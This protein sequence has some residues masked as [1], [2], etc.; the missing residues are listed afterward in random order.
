MARTQESIYNSSVAAYV[1]SA[2]AAGIITIVPSAWSMYNTQ[3]LL[4]WT[5]A[6]LISQFEQLF[7]DYVATTEAIV[8]VA[9]PQTPKWFKHQMFLFQFDATTPQVIQLDDVNGTFSPF[10][11]TTDAT[12]RIVTSCSVVPGSRGSTLIKL[13]KG[14]TTP[15]PLTVTEL[16]AAQAYINYIAVTGLYYNAISTDS[17]KL[18][19]QLDVAYSGAYSAV[20][21]TNV[22][23][24][25]KA[26]LLGIPFDGVVKQDDLLVAIKAVTGVLEVIFVNVQARADTTP[27]GTGTDLVLANTVLQDDWQ[28]VAGYIVPETTAGYLL[29][30]YRTGSSGPLNLNLTAR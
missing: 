18:F 10:Y 14:G 15:V 17:D 21:Q 16:S 23:A 27:V 30:D 24:A 4:L 9:S 13:A 29:T 8:A 1:V 20:I 5:C 7:D 25:I 11:P 12:K 3:R 19:L 6:G 2:V 26:Y 28:T 22:I